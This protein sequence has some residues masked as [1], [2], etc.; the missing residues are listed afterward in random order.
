MDYHFKKCIERK[1][2]IRCKVEKDLICK[3]FS[4][5]ESDFKDSKDVFKIGKYKLA[6]ITAY[7]AMFH[8]ARALLYSKGYQEKSHFCLRSAIKALFV[9]KNLLEPSL[10]D[11]YD[12][13]KDLRENADYKADFSKESAEALVVKAKIFLKQTKKLLN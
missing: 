10:L 13:A 6:T 2:L 12:T 11:D 3:E 7:Y 5:A 4:A 8:A 9:D 1:K